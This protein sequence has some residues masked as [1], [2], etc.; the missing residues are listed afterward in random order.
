MLEFVR[1][2]NMKKIY[3]FTLGGSNYPSEKF[4]SNLRLFAFMLYDS[5]YNYYEE[6]T[7]PLNIND[8]IEY[9]QINFDKGR[10]KF[11][12]DLYDDGCTYYEPFVIGDQSVGL[13]IID[14][15]FDIKKI[16]SIAEYTLNLLNLDY[17]LTIN[18][19]PYYAKES[20]DE[21]NRDNALRMA[22]NKLGYKYIRKNTFLSK[23]IGHKIGKKVR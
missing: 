8:S 11:S 9:N 16:E 5:I 14:D 13:T 2:S 21:S 15:N 20:S 18:V 19:F 6:N 4:Y 1:D 12:S 7:T 22:F 10:Y 3:T 23:L 17:K